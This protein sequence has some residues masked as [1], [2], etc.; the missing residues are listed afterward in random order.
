MQKFINQFCTSNTMK[1]KHLLKL[2]ALAV[3]VTVS[4]WVQS[5]C[6]ID[7]N[8]NNS[9]N[10]PN[11]AVIGTIDGLNALTVGLISGAGDFYSGDRAMFSSIWTW[12]IINAD[13]RAQILQWN[14]Y[15]ESTSQEY[16]GIWLSGFQVVKLAN[17]I[18]RIAPNV[19]M[20]NELRNT[21]MGIAFWYK[22]LAL[23]ELAALFG[24]IPIQSLADAGDF[25]N[26]FNAPPFVSQAEAYATA[27][28]NL[29]SAIARFTAGTVTLTQDLIYSGNRTNWIAASRSLKARFF[30]HVKNYAAALTNANA[31]LAGAI[32]SVRAIANAS[33]PN[34]QANFGTFATNE[35]GFP[36]RADKYFMD[37]LQNIDP[38]RAN[39]LTRATGDDGKVDTRIARYFEAPTSSPAR[40]S[41]FGF[42]YVPVRFSARTG[43]TQRDSSERSPAGAAFLSRA[44]GG[45]GNIGTSFPILSALENSFIRAECQA[46]TGQLDSAVI[47]LNGFRAAGGLG[48]YGGT[49][50]QLDVVREILRQKYIALF[51]EGQAYHDMRRTNTLPRRDDGGGRAPLRF[52]YPLN[53]R[54]RRPDVPADND[55]L[56]STLVGNSIL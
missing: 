23:G 17:D 36:T 42:A 35:Q 40:G 21:Y 37:I 1:S 11:E 4:L 18:L 12:Q 33:N 44:T 56:V 53:E 14:D 43:A 9:P 22:A 19:S 29:D 55:A 46:R 45:Y 8:L 20:P 32:P 26:R 28:A 49:V 3:L 50:A 16:N 34:E 13:G 10:A 51:L 48:N 30:L 2:S 39:S 15:V 25:T 52:S 5:G 24:S 31:G 7:P 54:Q 27:Q 47:L 6:N 38:V 41:F